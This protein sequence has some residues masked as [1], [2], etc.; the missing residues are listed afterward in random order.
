MT[1]HKS[2]AIRSGVEVNSAP[3]E[4]AAATRMSAWLLTLYAQ[5]SW[6]CPDILSLIMSAY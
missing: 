3:S 1:G 6:H 2:G 5:A 4:E